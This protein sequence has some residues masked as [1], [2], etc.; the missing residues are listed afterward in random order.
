[1]L[2]TLLQISS[3]SNLSENE[4]LYHATSSPTFSIIILTQTATI[5][6]VETATPTV[7]AT[8]ESKETARL[9]QRIRDFL[10][11]EGKYSEEYLAKLPHLGFDY[12]ETLEGNYLGLMKTDALIDKQFVRDTKDWSRSVYTLAGFQGVYLGG[13]LKDDHVEFY[14]GMR[15]KSGNR[16]VVPIGKPLF[17]EDGDVL[18]NSF[19]GTNTG[20]GSKNI[21]SFGSSL[22]PSKIDDFGRW[23]K[24]YDQ[25]AIFSCNLTPTSGFIRDIIYDIHGKRSEEVLK[26]FDESV[27]FCRGL[28]N[29][30]EDIRPNQ[31]LILDNVDSNFVQFDKS[32]FNSVEGVNYTSYPYIAYDTIIFVRP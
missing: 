25:I 23:E 19:A 30:T 27:P 7:E 2:I 12:K 22:I 26:I 13:Q 1:M 10:N 8:V 16:F 17:P 11:G 28:V 15:N 5:P 21:L 32:N 4:N 20:G 24:A 29:E 31:M 9:N 3:C 18:Y 6:I 14:I